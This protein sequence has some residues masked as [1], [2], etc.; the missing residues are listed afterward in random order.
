VPMTMAPTISMPAIV[1][2]RRIGVGIVAIVPE[3]VSKIRHLVQEPRKCGPHAMPEIA[4]TDHIIAAVNQKAD[5]SQREN[6][7]KELFQLPNHAA[8]PLLPPNLGTRANVH[9]ATCMPYEPPKANLLKLRK[10]RE[11]DW[12]V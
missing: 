6:F 8:P 3:P 4:A 7:S 12:I 10:K 9:K 11:A 5:D 2:R 1:S